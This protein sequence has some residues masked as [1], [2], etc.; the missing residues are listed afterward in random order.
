MMKG[1]GVDVL[2][3]YHLTPNFEIWLMRQA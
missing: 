1:E 3:V 2:D